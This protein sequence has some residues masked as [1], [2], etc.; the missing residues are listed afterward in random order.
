MN[1]TRDWMEL[2]ISEFMTRELAPAEILSFEAKGFRPRVQPGAVRS[3]LETMK[4]WEF[5]GYPGYFGADQ[6][7]FQVKTLW[8]SNSWQAIPCSQRT[9]NRDDRSAKRRAHNSVCVS[10][11]SLFTLDPPDNTH[12][13][14]LELS[15]APVASVVENIPGKTGRANSI[16]RFPVD[17]QSA[18]GGNPGTVRCR[19]QAAV[20][21]DP[22]FLP[23]R[24]THRVC[25]ADR[26]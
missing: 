16:V 9:G 25:R 1:H 18:V 4:N 3:R 24:F 17:K 23:F 8:I 26:P 14:L 6:A 19:L 5:T 7:V 13:L 21:I 11:S 20:E 15:A 2:E 12:L 10:R 22:N